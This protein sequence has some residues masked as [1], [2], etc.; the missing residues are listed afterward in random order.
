V[1]DKPVSSRSRPGNQPLQIKI[2]GITNLADAVASIECGADA[3]GF[4]LFSGSKRFIDIH[5]ESEWIFKLPGGVRKVAVMVNPRIDE[6]IKIGRL[7][8]IDSLQLH[9]DESAKFCSD[10]AAAKIVF[11][12]AIPILNDISIAQPVQFSTTDIL[13]DSSVDGSFGGTGRTFS[14][15]LAR[16]FVDAHPELQVILAGGLNPENVAAAIAEVRPAGVDVTTGVESAPGRKDKLR[17]QAFISAAR[18]A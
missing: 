17:L 13:L 14:W 11:T 5:R 16:R 7:P 9:G 8:F 15:S 10:L 4:N 18:Q 12:K 3:L 1:N 6:A 2:C